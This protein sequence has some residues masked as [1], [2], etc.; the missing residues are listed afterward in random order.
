MSIIE[1]KIIKEIMIALTKNTI[2]I[3]GKMRKEESSFR[4]ISKGKIKM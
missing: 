1:I 3:A 4:K 2:I